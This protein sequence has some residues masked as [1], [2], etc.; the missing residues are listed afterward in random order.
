[1]ADLEVGQLIKLLMGALVVALVVL[2]LGFYFKDKVFNFFDGLSN[3][4]EVSDNGVNL[5]DSVGN[6]G[7]VT[8]NDVDSDTAKDFLKVCSNCG[9]G[10]LN[11]CD[12][13]ECELISRN[14][15]AAGRVG[16]NFLSRLGAFWGKCKSK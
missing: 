7:I 14:R 10:K 1:M 8:S 2:G 15:I 9:D 12:E 4:E 6:S 11:K 16:C 13:E 3:G 5:E